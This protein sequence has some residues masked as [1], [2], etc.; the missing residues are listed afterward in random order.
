VRH[1]TSPEVVMKITLAIV[2]G[3]F[4]AGCVGAAADEPEAP[5]VVAAVQGCVR[6]QPRT[7]SAHG[8]VAKDAPADRTQIRMD[9]SPTGFVDDACD[10]DPFP[11]PPTGFAADCLA[12]PRR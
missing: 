4:V 12:K 2:L 7:P 3:T 9:D 8:P 11:I 5:D 10:A 1:L 6:H